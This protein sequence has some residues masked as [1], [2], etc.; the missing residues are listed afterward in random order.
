MSH[1]VHVIWPLQSD[2]ILEPYQQFKLIRSRL[3]YSL[4]YNFLKALKGQ[5]VPTKVFTE[6]DSE[7]CDQFQ[8]NELLLQLLAECEGDT[9][10]RTEAEG[11]A[12]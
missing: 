6:S 8:V 9:V 12:D 4:A 5:R 10:V 7:Q 11:A 2:T 1:P 3:F